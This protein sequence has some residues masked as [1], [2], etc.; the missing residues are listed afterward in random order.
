MSRPKEPVLETAVA[1]VFIDEEATV[2]AFEAIA[3][4]GYDEGRIRQIGKH[5]ELIL[6]LTVDEEEGADKEGERSSRLTATD[7]PSARMP[8]KTAAEAPRPR[9][10]DGSKPAV[11]AKRSLWEKRRRREG[12]NDSKGRFDM[13]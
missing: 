13:R 12:S 3:E 11:A 9:E 1:H 10:Q 5:L 8:R 2:A 6:E 4:E 7:L